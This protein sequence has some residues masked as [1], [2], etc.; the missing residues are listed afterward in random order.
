MAELVATPDYPAPDFFGER[1]PFALFAAW[2][3]EASAA[4]INDPNAMALA[5]VDL[6]GLPNVRVVLLKGLDGPGVASDARGFVFYT[7]ME[8]AK[9]R[10]LLGS[11]KA[12][13]NFHWKSLRRQVRIRGAV[14]TVPDAEADAYFATRPR[15]SQIGA[16]ASQQSRDL[17]A[18]ATLEAEIARLEAAYPPETAIPRP[19]HWTG[20]RLMPAEIEFWCERRFRLHDRSVFTRRAAGEPWSRNR[21]YP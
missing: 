3:E 13:L 1:D 16:W 15:G 5:T 20:F 14:A 10:E 17:D 12:A 21:L 19:P 7:N 9:G 18:R 2:F 11:G 4:E 8:S 6:S